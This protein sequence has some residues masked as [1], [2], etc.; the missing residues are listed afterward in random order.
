MK[1]REFLQLSLQRGFVLFFPGDVEQ[2]ALPVERMPLSIPNQIGIFLDP[3]NGAIAPDQAI[4]FEEAGGAVIGFYV[5]LKD[6]PTVI[7]MDR[8]RP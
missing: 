4:F 2:D 7:R 8:T 5:L 1:D 6:T 3:N